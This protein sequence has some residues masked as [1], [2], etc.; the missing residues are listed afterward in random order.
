MRSLKVASFTV[1][2]TEK[3]SI[4]WKRAAEA[5]GHASV[6]TW[7]SEAADRHLD[8]LQRAGRPIPLSWHR[9]RFLVE[10]ESGA[11]VQVRGHVSPPFGSYAGTEEGPSTYAGRRRHV[12]VYVPSG[13]ILATFRSY[14]HCQALASELARVWVRWGGSEPAEDPAPVLHRFQ[15]EDV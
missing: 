8:A 14:A 6:G 10:L 1:R 11:S 15:R 5:D 7:L 9:G 2:A 3:Q 13:R 4:R 12:L